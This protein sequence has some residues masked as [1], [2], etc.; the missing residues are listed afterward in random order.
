MAM[1]DLPSLLT[2]AGAGALL[3]AVLV[4]LWAS[5]RR[6]RDLEPLQAVSQ[7]LALLQQRQQQ[8][9]EQTAEARALQTQ[10]QQRFE[11]RDREARQL[12]LARAQLVERVHQLERLEEENGDLERSLESAQQ[13]LSRRNEQLV[14]LESRT[15]VERQAQAEKLR[16]LTEARDQ[17]KSEFQNLANRIFD[18][19][20]ARFSASNRD[21]IGQLLTPLR[22]QIGDFKRRVEDVYD[23]EAKDRRALSEQIHQLKQLNQQMSQDAINLTR[24][25]KGES[26]TQ[27]NWGEVV[28]ARVLESSGLRAGYEFEMQVSLNEGSKRYQPDVIVRL[29]DNKDVIIDAK[30]S[31]TAYEQYCSSEDEAE[32]ARQLRDHLQSL[33]NHV[34]GLGDKAYQGL[35]GVR[36]LDF[37][38]QFIPIE[39]AFLL[40][41]EQDPEL[42]RYA[43]ERNIILVSPTTLLVTLRTINH[44]WRNEYQNRNAQEIARRG[45]ELIDKFAGFVESVDDIGRH[46]D[47]GRQAWETAHK[48]LTSGRG[49]LVSQAAALHR[50]GAVGKK[51]LPRGA[52]DEM[53]EEDEAALG[54]DGGEA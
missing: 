22:E 21:S 15:E 33:R 38:L 19:K 4:L 17:L 24:A 25:L 14:E 6:S 39:G 41:L 20:S 42:M 51:S 50:L 43:Y 53:D 9:Q 18:E 45:G 16:L 34:R 47:R 11:Q 30:V 52:D 8:L 40:A 46:L 13:L 48:R 44:I 54:L 3:A 32:R 7:E 26:K 28:L 23:R 31:L 29:P 12:E 35:E 36:T 49:S 27:G 5:V 37:V 2:G 10:W 1:L